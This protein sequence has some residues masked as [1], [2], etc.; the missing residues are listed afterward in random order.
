MGNP[1]LPHVYDERKHCWYLEAALSLRLSLHISFFCACLDTAGSLRFVCLTIRYGE[2]ID[3]PDE[4]DEGDNPMSFPLDT[5][6][7]P[8]RKKMKGKRVQRRPMPEGEGEDTEEGED[9]VFLG[10]A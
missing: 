10:D 1:F 8:G 5:D 2:K 3:V 7:V 4:G 9:G 6:E